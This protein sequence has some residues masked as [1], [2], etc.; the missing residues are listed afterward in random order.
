MNYLNY[1]HTGKLY[2]G[3]VTD[4]EVGSDFQLFVGNKL[5]ERGYEVQQEIGVKGFFIDIGVKH[6]KYPNK[7]LIGVECDGAAY[8]SSKSA[9]D[10]DRLRQDILEGLGW[11]IYRI[12]L[13]DWFNNPENEIN[14]LVDY[15]ENKVQQT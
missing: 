6:P 9:R 3:E 12:W 14:K 8:H 15:I 1:A 13:T 11:D 4:R 7:Y 2:S 5:K 10:R